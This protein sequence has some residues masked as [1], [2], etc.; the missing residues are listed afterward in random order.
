MAIATTIVLCATLPP[1]AGAHPNLSEYVQHD[2]TLTAGAI[3]ADL[4]VRLTFFGRHAEIQE[5]LLDADGDGH[6][7]LEE[8]QAFRATLLKSASKHVALT[9]D[10]EPLDLLPL[11]EPAL[12][13]GQGG[14]EG[15][16]HQRFEITLKFFAR[17]PAGAQGPA[18]LE[19]HDRLY[20]AYAALATFKV[21][22]EDSRRLS[23]QDTGH[24]LARPAHSN[25]ALI[26]SALLHPPRPTAQSGPR[27]AQDSEGET[28]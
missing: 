18:T 24:D 3:Y 9:A 22:A 12:K 26:L 17:L 4:T 5:I 19:I 10:G 11:N 2:I 13:A 23:V 15:A 25:D 28:P 8:R 21:R 7:G 27:T 16:P 14:P 20:P 6:A 1:R